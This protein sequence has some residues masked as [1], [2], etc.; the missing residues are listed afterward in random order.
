MTLRI[1]NSI[2]GDGGIAIAMKNFLSVLGVVLVTIGMMGAVALAQ[3]SD[4][5][6]TLGD[7]ARQTRAQV[8][9]ATENK[10]SK[11]QG[12]VDEMQRE[13]ERSDNTP[14]G[15]TNYDAGDYNLFVPFPFSLEG[16]ENGGVVLLGSRLGVT[17]TEVMAG[18]PIP[19]PATLSDTDLFNLV[20][21]LATQHGP[22][23]CFSTRL[24]ARQAFRFGL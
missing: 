22:A 7:V 3:D 13:Q 20:R 18:T 8:A 4:S 10:S 16:R 2:H 9:A 1:S 21:Q 19:M 14:T 12:L 23:S 6:N 5:P 24:G 17:N 15:F 11:A